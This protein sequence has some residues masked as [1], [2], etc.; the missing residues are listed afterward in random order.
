MR[1]SEFRVI[2]PFAP[3]SPKTSAYELHE[4][5]H[6]SLRVDKQDVH[7][8][9][10]EGI[11]RQMYIKFTTAQKAVQFTYTKDTRHCTHVHTNGERTRV[12]FPMVGFGIRQ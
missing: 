2:F 9:Q 8:T 6:D 1:D 3:N 4:W 5:T 10:I 12:R 7:A 11:R